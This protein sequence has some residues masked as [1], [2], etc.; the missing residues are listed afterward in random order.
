[1]IKLWQDVILC[2]QDKAA[3]G[4]SLYLIILNFRSTCIII[5]KYKKPMCLDFV[6]KVCFVVWIVFFCLQ[7]QQLYS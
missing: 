6:A 7:S 2:Y 5:K 3:I 4:R 1:M